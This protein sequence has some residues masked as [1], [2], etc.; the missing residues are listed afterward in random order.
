MTSIAALRRLTTPRRALLGALLAAA[1]LTATTLAVAAVHRTA[2]GR[3]ELVVTRSAGG[4]TAISGVEL[5]GPSGSA[6]LDA[7]APAVAAAPQ[8]TDLGEFEVPAGLYRE[9]TVRIGARTLTVPVTVSIGGDRLTPVLVALT[10]SGASAYTG[11]DG[12]N[13]GLLVAGGRM[14][15]VPPTTFTDQG[16]RP[17]SL[18]GRPT[19]VASF[20]THC[21]ESCPLYTAVLADLE[22]TLRARGWADRVQIA[23][24]TMDPQRDTPSTLAAYARLTGASWELLTAEPAPLRVFWAALHASYHTVP[25]PGTPP[26]DWQT[27]RPE[28]YDVSHDSLAAVLDAQGVPRFVLPG[29]PRLGHGLSAPLARMLA[30]EPVPPAGDSQPRAPAGGDAAASSWSL[31][32]LLDRIDTLLGEPGEAD[33]QPETALRAGAPAP[34]VTLPRLDGRRVSLADELGHPVILNFWATWCGPCRRELPLL[35]RAAAGHP[36]LSILALDEG[37]DAATVRD[38]LGGMPGTAPLAL[39]DTERSAGAAYAVGGLPVSIAVDAGGTVR[40]VHVGELTPAE[41]DRL[42]AASGAAGGA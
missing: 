8:P 35:A 28:A 27:G 16:G 42:V 36:E 12:V 13:L 14:A 20:E 19:V 25:Y 9:L 17:V 10:R 33:R 39:L 4:A 24:V 5:S 30:P 26:T 7:S 34:A 3:V 37:E 38:F 6:R 23:E 40:A 41:L 31:T 18:G 22:R 2:T 11:N 21:H 29:N 15:P 1:L 32:D